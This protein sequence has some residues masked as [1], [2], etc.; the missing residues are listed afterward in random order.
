MQGL[1]RKLIRKKSFV[2]DGGKRKGETR[3]RVGQKEEEEEEEGK[4]PWQES[5]RGRGGKRGERHGGQGIANFAENFCFP[6][7]CLFPEW[8]PP[9]PPPPPP[10]TDRVSEL[11]AS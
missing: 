1:R 4:V 2:A 10:R 6:S 11:R 8:R 9:P 7:L 3:E 5:G